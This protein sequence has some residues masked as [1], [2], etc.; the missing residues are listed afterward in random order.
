MLNFEHVLNLPITWGCLIAF[1]VLLYVVLDGFDL[2]VGILFPFAPSEDCRNKMMNSIA[3]FWDGNETWL[4][5]GGASVFAAFPLA[6]SLLMPAFYLPI[7]V[8]LLG[9][10]LRGVAFEFRFKSTKTRSFWGYIF[11]FSSI[12]ATFAQGLILGTFVQ[13]VQVDKATRT[14]IGTAFD[15]L[16][17]FSIMT[18]IALMAAYALIGACWVIWKTTDQTQAWAK[19]SA[20]YLV[21]YVI[22]FMGLVSVSIPCLNDDIRL[23][24]F[25]YQNLLCLSPIPILALF[26]SFKLIHHLKNLNSSNEHQP[27]F[28]TILLFLCNYVGLGISLWPWIVPFEVTLVEAAAAPES[29]SLLLLGV[30]CFLPLILFYTGYCY[31]TFKGKVE[32]EFY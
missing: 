31:F 23:L 9:L 2:G 17:P 15:W 4:V 7:T 27:F 12:V 30:A 24:W 11:H 10:V 26:F 5:L 18:G 28:Y 13:G 6:Y 16:T 14:F 32:T 20:L 29:Q 21:A 25:S 19:K 22:L 1:I 8:M 3:P